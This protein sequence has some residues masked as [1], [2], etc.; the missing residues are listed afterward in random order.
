MGIIIP[1]V[2]DVRDRESDF[3]DNIAVLSPTTD[4]PA[5]GPDAYMLNRADFPHREMPKVSG[6]RD[7]RYQVVFR[8]SVLDEIHAHGKS[9]MEA[10]VC[11]VLVGDVYFDRLAG[12]AYVEHCI[13]GNN[14]IAKQTEVTFTSDTWS[15]IHETLDEKYPGKKI[16]GWYHT[17]PGFGIF[18]SG[19]D[20]FIQDNFFNRSWQV[21]TVYD[22]HSE[23]E[24]TFIW[25]A[26]KSLREN[27]LVEN[28]TGVAPPEPGQKSDAVAELTRRV[29]RLERRL[30]FLLTGFLFLVLLALVSPL[31][32]F[33]LAPDM[34]RKLPILH[35]PLFN[36]S[37]LPGP[38]AAPPGSKDAQPTSQ[39]ATQPSAAMPSLPGATGYDTRLLRPNPPD[40]DEIP[41]GPR[42]LLNKGNH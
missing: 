33:A 26:G 24:G 41:A 39:P 9:S 30:D 40:D 5:G 34:V 2:S 38:A 1:N 31:I 22:P 8:Q 6:M 11:G 14:A 42:T 18:L 23:D 12:W 29:K 32:V 20:L 17:H 13:R 28:D 35:Y 4:P 37:L 7:A 10:E 36:K 27:V 25:R 3:G 19:M 16:L 15:R 21:A